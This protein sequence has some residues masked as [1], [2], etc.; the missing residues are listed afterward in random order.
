MCSGKEF[1]QVNSMKV[2]VFAG[3]GKVADHSV[4]VIY[5]LPVDRNSSNWVLTFR[6][7]LLLEQ[8]PVVLSQ[9]LFVI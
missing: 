7:T 8:L 3:R 4:Q 6:K 1:L 5:P 9:S 2:I